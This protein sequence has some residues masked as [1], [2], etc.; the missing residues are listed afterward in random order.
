M[1]QTPTTIKRR[2]NDLMRDGRRRRGDSE[3]IVFFCECER[4]RC[5]QG[6]SLF[7]SEY[8]RLRSDA[9]WAALLPGHRAAFAGDQFLGATAGDAGSRFGGG[10]TRGAVTPRGFTAAVAA[11]GRAD[12]HGHDGHHRRP[13]STAG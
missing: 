6:V 5:W 7:A 4:Q 11:G 9:R 10:P 12:S 3:R 13:K 2:A 1:I 8:D